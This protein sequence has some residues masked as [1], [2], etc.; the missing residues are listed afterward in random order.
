MQLVA[1]GSGSAGL[2]APD[3]RG[4]DVALVDSGVVPVGGLAQPGRV[5]YGPDFSSE[6]NDPD[7]RNLDTFG[8][9]TH[10]AGLITGRRHVRRAELQVHAKRLDRHLGHDTRLQ[11]A[12][13]RYFGARLKLIRRTAVEQDSGARRGRHAHRRAATVHFYQ[14]P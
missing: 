13:G 6:R 7:L 1:G 12:I 11:Q 8:H 14:P 5:V 3:G 4:V 2:S 9:G 10:L